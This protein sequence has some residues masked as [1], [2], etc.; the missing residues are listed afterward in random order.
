MIIFGTTLLQMKN[1]DFKLEWIIQNELESSQLSSTVNFSIIRLAPFCNQL[2]FTSKLTAFS[3][4]YV[5][6]IF[7]IWQYSLHVNGHKIK[8]NVTQVKYEPILERR[9][10]EYNICQNKRNNFWPRSYTL[11]PSSYHALL[12][13]HFHCITLIG[14]CNL[15]VEP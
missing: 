13:E 14:T 11:N 12:F 9:K 3:T 1:R 4:K 6:P 5:S 10:I 2:Q 8:S 15:I 7:Y